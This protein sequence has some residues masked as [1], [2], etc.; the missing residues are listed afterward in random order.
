LLL[1]LQLTTCHSPES[2]YKT[3][4]KEVD[5]GEF[6]SALVKAD[7]ALRQYGSHDAKWEWLFRLL[8]ARILVSRSQGHEALSLLRPEPPPELTSTEIPEQ[9][10]LLQGIA[11]R[12]T[13]QFAEA[14]HDFAETERLAR[15]LEPTYTCQLLI[16]RA[17]LW[18]DEKKYE[19]ARVDYLSALT[20]TRSHSLSI[21]EA[22][23]LADLA[24]LATSQSHFDEALDLYFSALQL[25]NSL[26]IEG[27][28]ATI[29]GNLGWAYSELGDFEASL[30]YY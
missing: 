28:A 1:A 13:Q 26:E 3:L 23:T 15:P 22:D 9:R 20:L 12:S 24:R 17:A 8:K 7:A 18:V 14:E 25:A 16:A 2:D 21:L 10:K 29:L 27:T 5:R 11:H 4:K 30:A 19:A 6:N